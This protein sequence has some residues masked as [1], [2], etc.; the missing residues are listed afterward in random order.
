M[1]RKRIVLSHK[2]LITCIARLLSGKEKQIEDF[3]RGFEELKRELDSGMAAQT[4]FVTVRTA[5][6]IDTLCTSPYLM[7]VGTNTNI[8]VPDTVL[9]STLNPVEGN[10]FNRPQCL[11]STRLEIRREIM[12]WLLSEPKEN[13]LW[14]YGVAGSGKSTVM[15][16]IAEYLR[17]LHRLGA[18]LFFERSKSDPSSIFRTLAYQLASFDPFIA[19]SVNKVVEADNGIATASAGRQFDQLIKTPLIES[20]KDVDG[21]IVIILDALDECGTPEARRN[22]LQLLRYGLP[23]LPPKYLFLI[24]SRREP[25][26]DLA[27]SDNPTTIRME[28]NFATADTRRDVRFYLNHEL[29]LAIEYVGITVPSTWPWDAHLGRLAEMADGLF[30][31][32]STVVRIVQRS[33]NPFQKLQELSEGSHH[34]RG[35]DELYATALRTSG[36]SW[37]EE[38]SRERFSLVVSLLLLNRAPISDDMIDVLLG[39]SDAKPSYLVLSKL[40]SILVYA[41]GEPIRFFH[42]S[43]IDYLTSPNRRHDPWF[44]N[45]P[46]T[47]HDVVIRCLITMED[48]LSFNIGDID[49]SFTGNIKIDEE[50]L[51]EIIPPHLRYA[52]LCWAGHLARARFS[53]Q[54]MEKLSS[55]VLQRLLWWFEVMSL[56]KRFSDVSM[57]LESASRWTSVSLSTS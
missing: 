44:I 32:A 36:I 10:A 40:R 14:V 27:L 52:C 56:L 7:G 4:V 55:F 12:N 30:V 20:E 18:F 16:S 48:S 54:L 57:V 21:P 49:S 5:K 41:K 2:I 51:R 19:T 11:D 3:Q 6:T 23:Q 1:V 9:Q 43:L 33:D 26:I 24:T 25:D 50:K 45:I 31:W 46:T 34:L 13:V 15:M 37:E 28:L 8:N 38:S 17:S 29:R 47:E 35:M 22:M 42:S 53:T 39:F